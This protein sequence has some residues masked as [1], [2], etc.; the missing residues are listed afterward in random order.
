MVQEYDVS[1]D[2]AILGSYYGKLMADAK[3]AGRVT[4]VSYDPRI[5]VETWWDLGIGDS[6]AIWFVEWSILLFSHGAM[7]TARCGIS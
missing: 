1:F 7:G 4:R 5:L 3:T 6:T 2:A